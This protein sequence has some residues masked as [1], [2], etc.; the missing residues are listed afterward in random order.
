MAPPTTALL[1]SDQPTS[2]PTP[3]PSTPL[4]SIA[5]HT[6]RPTAP[7]RGGGCDDSLM[8]VQFLGGKTM[9]GTIIGGQKTCLWMDHHN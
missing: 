3:S 2:D 4:P 7:L 6:S 5:R 1:T 8:V 9:A